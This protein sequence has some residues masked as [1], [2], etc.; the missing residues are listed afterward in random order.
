M[1]ISQHYSRQ[2]PT[3]SASSYHQR[4]LP[5]CSVAQTPHQTSNLWFCSS[6]CQ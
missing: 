3:E 6:V 1:R 4:P 5:R 2:S